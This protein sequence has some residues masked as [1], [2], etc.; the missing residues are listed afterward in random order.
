MTCLQHQMLTC[1]IASLGPVMF[2]AGTIYYGLLNT[3]E[4]IIGFKQQLRRISKDGNWDQ[5]LT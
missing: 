2:K 5:G 1:G 3:L 4:T